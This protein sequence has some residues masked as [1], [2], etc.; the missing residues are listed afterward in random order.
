M[1]VAV[2]S[3]IQFASVS[4]SVTSVTSS[5]VAWMSSASHL[6]RS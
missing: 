6:R 2:A 5:Y 3:V 1:Q 4:A